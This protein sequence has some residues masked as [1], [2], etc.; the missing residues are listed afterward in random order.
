MVRLLIKISKKYNLKVVHDAAQ[1][2]G[3]SIGKK[4]VGSFFDATC[5]I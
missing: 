2:L 1:S 5:F 3:A 4:K